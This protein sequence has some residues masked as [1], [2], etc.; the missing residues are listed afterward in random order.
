M[1]NFTERAGG[2]FKNIYDAIEKKLN[3]NKNETWKYFMDL[4]YEKMKKE[5]YELLTT[6]KGLR[7]R[8]DIKEIKSMSSMD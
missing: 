5:I 6:D 4:F 1:M 8:L 2:D 3:E 7:D